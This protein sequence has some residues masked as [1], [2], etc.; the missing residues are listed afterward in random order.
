M[1]RYLILLLSLFFAV[2][3][4]AQ[5]RREALLEYQARRR[6]AYAEFQ[7]NYRKACAD[8][9]RKRWEA[10]RSEAPVPLPERKEPPQPVVKQPDESAAP[11]QDRIPYKEVV[12]APV[13]TVPAIPATPA[14]PEVPGAPEEPDGPK[15]PD[16]PAEPKL[17]GTKKDGD[18]TP[19]AATGKGG[20]APAVV[21]SRPYRFTFYGT[22]CSVSLAA[23]HRFKLASLQENSV[24]DAWERVAGGAYDPVAKECRELK[25]QLRLNDW[26]Y[27]ALVRT[28]SDG[29][30]GKQSA[31]SVVLQ[32]FLMAE[33]GC[34]VR[35]A[36]GGDRLCLLLAL[37]DQVYAKPY[38]KIDGQ[39][40]YLLDDMARA[41]SYNICNF[42]MPGERPL[43]LAMP[44]PPVLAQ[45][46]GQPAVR[47]C[48]EGALTT[49]VAV[50]RNLMDFYTDYPP[51]YWS[52]YA[53]TELTP[54][55][56]DQLY[57][58]LRS[59]LAGKGE[60]D[61]ANLLLPYLHRAFP[62]KTD[63]AQ[64]GVE[65]TLF[66][67]EMFHYP[68]SDCEDR[69]ILFA[70]LVRD[71]MKLDV[72]LLYYPEHIATAVCFKENVKGD[73]M[74]IGAKRYVVCDPTYVGADVGDAMPDLKRV[75]AQVVKID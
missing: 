34:K 5:S 64:F 21:T 29:F 51:C 58:T 16:A 66:A 75:A 57:P 20:P 68:Y 24:A 62:Y 61:A 72:V 49:T 42:R 69:S 8:F 52:I 39:T 37:D 65:R 74:Q 43:S 14:A 67:E 33:A 50:N 3:L 1:K 41:A 13:R 23:K 70:R 40:F 44:V 11:T 38:F 4:A 59:A 28:L 46:S 22:E 15:A 31:E 47:K 35:L 55:V 45:K 54:A 48:G 18:R 19:P 27:Y 73:Y 12:E 32:S 9:M 25:E 10:F 17:P 2:P 71:L 7:D 6:Q 26:G 53:A 63:E 60:Y 36:R 56:R 30:F